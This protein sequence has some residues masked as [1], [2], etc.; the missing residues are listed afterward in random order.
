MIRSRDCPTA[1]AAVKPKMRSAP[2]F[3]NRITPCASAAMIASALLAIT[4]ALRSSAIAMLVLPLRALWRQLGGARG[5]GARFEDG[6]GGEPVS[7]EFP[8]NRFR[9]VEA[10]GQHEREF[11]R[12]GAPLLCVD[13][14]A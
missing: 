6:V 4:A 8:E 10:G 2:R 12:A 3:Q 14:V 1:S 9:A 5:V 7:P 13:V 11:P